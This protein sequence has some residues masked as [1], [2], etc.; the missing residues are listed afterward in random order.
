MVNRTWA[1]L[2]GR[3]FVN[4]IDDM[5]EENVPSHPELLDKLSRQFVA[6]GYD[7][8]G[9]VRAIC[10][11]EAYQRTSKPVPGSDADRG[12]ALFARMTVKVMSPEQLFDSLNQVTGL[13]AIQARR[14][15]KN[16]NKR[17]QLTARD[18]FVQ[19]YLAGAE[20]ASATEYDAGIPQA[21][22]LMNSRIVGNP[23]SARRIVGAGTPP[24]EAFEAIYLTALSRRP[25]SEELAKLTAYLRNAGSA[26]EAYSD[27]L[28][29]VLNSSEFSMVR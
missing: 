18:R 8:K 1:Q 11:S 9:L 5:H 21:L 24:R 17:Q 6:N 19:F 23:N 4:P 10:L 12:Q 3:G 13:A 16:G 27:V 26:N 25:T 14:A 15:G 7:L 28:W 22:K 2:F 20:Q 29:A